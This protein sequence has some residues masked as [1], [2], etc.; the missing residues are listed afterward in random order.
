MKQP[1]FTT[2][3]MTGLA[4]VSFSDQPTPA[5]AD[6]PAKPL[7]KAD[8]PVKYLG[9]HL[10]LSPNADAAFYEAYQKYQ[11]GQ[12]TITDL[13]LLAYLLCQDGEKAVPTRVVKSFIEFGADVNA[14]DEKSRTPLH[15]AGEQGQTES[16]KAL[17]AAGADV[18]A[19]DGESRTPLYWAKLYGHKGVAKILR[20]AGGKE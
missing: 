17:L 18:N 12:A 9:A 7:A 20:T 11:K 1:L 2:L 3:F 8:D 14:K 6:A 16:V 10:V 19:K 13:P 15:E 4:L 5:K